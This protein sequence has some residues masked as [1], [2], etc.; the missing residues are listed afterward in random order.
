MHG[1]LDHI[2]HAQQYSYNAAGVQRHCTSCVFQVA[3]SFGPSTWPSPNAR[4]A[5]R[6]HSGTD[7]KRTSMIALTFAVL[8]DYAECKM[9]YA[10]TFI[11]HAY[12]II[13]AVRELSP[14]QRA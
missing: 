3:V 5:H 13:G 7:D 1:P 10:D 14:L 6:T 4:V 11:V 2:S 8:T 12:P 9:H